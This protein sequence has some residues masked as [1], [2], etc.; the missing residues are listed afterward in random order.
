MPTAKPP[1]TPAATSPLPA[2]ALWG[3]HVRQRLPVISSPTRNVRIFRPLQMRHLSFQLI[4]A[5]LKP[6]G[7]QIGQIL[8]SNFASDGHREAAGVSTTKS[9]KPKKR[10]QC[11]DARRRVFQDSEILRALCGRRLAR[12]CRVYLKKIA[13]SAVLRVS[14]IMRLARPARIRFVGE[15]LPYHQNART[16]RAGGDRRKCRTNSSLRENCR[17]S[18]GAKSR[19][20]RKNLQSRKAK[21]HRGPPAAGG[22]AACRRRSHQTRYGA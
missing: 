17:C 13:F 20:W 7:G 16:R 11:R 2:L 12:C 3:A 14:L 18:I 15:R 21:N 19:N 9:P 22:A 10:R 4:Y 1:T 6:L 5:A 8:G